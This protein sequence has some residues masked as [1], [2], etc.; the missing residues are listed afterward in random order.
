VKTI[1]LGRTDLQVSRSGFGAIPI[2]RI[3]I[4]QAKHLLLKAYRGGINFF[5]TARTYTDSEEKIG[6]ALSDVREEIILA[7]KSPAVDRDGVLQDLET[8]LEK[9]QTDYVDIYQLHNPKS[10]PDPDDP[11]GPYRATLEAKEQGK[12]R[13]IG[14]TNH[15]LDVAL[16][17][18]A[19]DL[20]DT[21]QFPLSSLSS[22]ED[23]QLIEECKKRDIGVIAMKALSGGLIT[24]VPATFTFLRQYDNVVPIWGIERDA[25]LDEFLSLE[26]NPPALNEEMWQAIE[27]DRA[28]LSGA[29]CRGCGYCLPCPVDIPIN[30]AAR[31]SYLLDRSV[32][33]RFLT[34]EWKEKMERIADCTE[35]GQ[36]SDRCPYDLDTPSLL[37]SQLESYRAFY[38]EHAGEL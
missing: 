7:T 19:S 10:L 25:D 26:Q 1:R 2:Q 33:Q 9:L 24:N 18:A 15:R 29:F 14:F 3:G 8:S 22:D 36:C 23:L 37:K 13:F 6:V 35:C 34:D 4:D 16:E 17:A 20:Y 30:M 12:I 32:Y 21:I 27:R 11:N 28:E 31:L 5:D 38:Q